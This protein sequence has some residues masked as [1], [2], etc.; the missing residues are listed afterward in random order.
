MVLYAACPPAANANDA[1]AP[2]VVVEGRA[3]I[4]Q[5]CDGSQQPT[6][7]SEAVKQLTFAL[8]NWVKRA[9]QCGKTRCIIAASFMGQQGQVSSLFFIFIVLHCY[10]RDQIERDDGDVRR[11]CSK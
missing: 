6:G 3:K 10:A 2:H 4:N 1:P 9:Q 8:K 5:L 7:F 11:L